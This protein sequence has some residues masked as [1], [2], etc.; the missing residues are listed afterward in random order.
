MEIFIPFA[1]GI[2]YILMSVCVMAALGVVLLPNIFYAAL[3][4]VGV[5][6]G[7]AGIYIALHADFLAVVQILIYV[8]AVM[9]LVIFAIMLTHSLG[10][11]K[12][13]EHNRLAVPALILS[14]FFFFFLAKWIDA[15]PWPIRASALAIV[16][17]QKIGEAFMQTY[18]FPFEVISVVLIAALVGAVVIARREKE[19]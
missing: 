17:T 10:S 1:R 11:K 5:L 9:T 12:G 4:L 14:T 7:T 19:V 16:S 15:A 18:I 6:I 13:I 2:L 3:C 8:G